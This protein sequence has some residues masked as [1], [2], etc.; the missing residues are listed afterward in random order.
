[1]QTRF[2]TEIA[3]VAAIDAIPK[4]LDVV[5]SVTGLGVAAVARAAEDR[6]VTCAIRD[7]LGLGLTVGSELKLGAGV[8]GETRE[9]G[10]MVVIDHLA[11]DTTRQVRLNQEAH[12]FQSYISAPVSRKGEFFGT[13]C[14]IDPRPARLNT[15]EIVKMFGLFADLI[16][17]YLDVSE[18]L[19]MKESELKEERVVAG[20]REEFIAVLGHD[21]R[22][23]L[24]AIDI[25]ALI[26]LGKPS[27]DAKLTTELALRVRKSTARMSALIEN[28]MDFARGRLGGGFTLTRLVTPDLDTTLE[29][30]VAEVRTRFPER[31]IESDIVI[32]GPVSVDPRR[33]SQLLSNLLSNGLTHGQAESPVTIRA[34][35]SAAGFELAVA[36]Q[37]PPI[38]PEKIARLFQPFTRGGSTTDSSGLGL[39]LYI[40]SEIAKAHGG[41]LT[42]RSGPETTRFTLNIPSSES[43][44]VS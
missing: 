39:G 18:R 33:I 20:L 19:A 11:K 28:L 40:A 6:W 37:G 8:W 26:L 2:E 12:Q 13:L 29:H 38:P 36:N 21:L 1:M 17:M 35:N 31:V 7:D 4:I 30:V 41:A 42:V 14:A 44:P 3:A 5:C 15:P 34:R 27:T 9:S 23:P 10:R 22:N 43:N 24:A 32:D 25:S 16:G